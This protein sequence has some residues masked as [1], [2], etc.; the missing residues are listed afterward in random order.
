MP[1][2]RWAERYLKPSEKQSD[3]NLS[4]IPTMISIA[5]CKRHTDNQPCIPRGGRFWL[6]NAT[7]RWCLFCGNTDFVFTL[8]TTTIFGVDAIA[9]N[10]YYGELQEKSNHKFAEA[11]I[12]YSSLFVI[13]KCFDPS[14]PFSDKQNIP[15]VFVQWQERRENWKTPKI[16]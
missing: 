14:N 6:L 5:W 10:M 3:V 8:T 13:L 16:I 12:F 11:V 15:F 1:F 7:C 9:T 4:H 2:N